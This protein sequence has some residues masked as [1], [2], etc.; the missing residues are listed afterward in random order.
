MSKPPEVKGVT[1]KEIFQAIK[2][3]NLW[4]VD[5]DADPKYVPWMF[6]TNIIGR[7]LARMTG[8]GP[9]GPVTVKCTADGS[10]AVVQRGG[11]FDDYEKIEHDFA[12][13]EGARAIDSVEAFHLKDSSETF[14]AD[15]ILAGSLVK[16]TTQTTYAL[17]TNVLD[18]DLTLDTDIME[19]VN[20]YLIIPYHEFTFAQQVTRIDIFT[21]DGKVDYQLTRDAVK[22]YGDKIELFEDSF[23]SLDFFTLKVRAT[24]VTYVDAT[25]TRSKVMGWFREGG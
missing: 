6:I 15:G 4:E 14:L 9:Y 2:S 3:E 7:V 13:T 22:P 24:P 16:N 11:A 19:G 25:P 23:Y 17:I 18:Y 21:Y 1:P 8:Q 10:L 5:L 12:K 20:N